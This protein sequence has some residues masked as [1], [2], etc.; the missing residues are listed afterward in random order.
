[1][2]GGGAAA[3]GR[4]GREPF[5]PRRS[6]AFLAARR[7]VRGIVGEAC[8][9]C[10]GV[11]VGVSGGA[12]SL[13]LAAACIAEAAALR[14]D[15]GDAAPVHAV[16]VDHGLQEGS[17]EVA[18]TAADVVRELGATAEVV[19]VTVAD[20]GD[21]PEAAARDARHAAL[22]RVAAALGRPLLLAHTLDD[23]AETVLL[24]L[25]RGSGPAALAGMSP[26]RTW[27]SGVRVVRPLL[28][29]R[30]VDT[31]A[32]CAEL[33]LRPWDDPHNSD[34]RFARVRARLDAL[35]VLEELLGPGVA[36]NLARTS[37]LLRDDAL[38]LDDWAAAE[39][40]AARDA[41]G[42]LRAADVAALPVAVRTRV[43]KTWAESAG[44]AGLGGAHVRALDKLVRE[45]NGRGPVALPAA[46]PGGRLVVAG[47]GGTL[48]VSR[49]TPPGTERS[50]PQAPP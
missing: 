26:D 12:D 45:R 37:D 31:V 11:V 3:G 32:A 47:K 19:A 10:G 34:R 8:A 1:M 30:R 28:G 44:A 33:S 29:L 18:R 22:H 39:L 36:A 25:A 35:P 13:A 24:G 23:Q 42:G 46:E 38:A 7:A 43:L 21:G 40:A 49:G 20:A 16:I 41:D 5:W 15:E 27:D 9:D 6:P 2:T 14:T 17:G 48:A 50:G 4:G